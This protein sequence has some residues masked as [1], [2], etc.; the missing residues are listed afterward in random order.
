MVVDASSRLDSTTHL[1]S[2]L[3][4]AVLVVAQTDVVSLWSASKIRAF[5]EEGSGRDRVRLV[6]NRYKKIPGF[7]DED[8]AKATNCAL[9]WKLPN[10]YQSIAPAIDKGAPVALHDNHDIGRSF[11]SLAATLADASATAE[12]SLDLT[13]RHDK[14]DGKKKAAGRLLISPL[15][16]GQ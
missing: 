4:N 2:D 8:V 5:L 13:Y 7:S 16:A 10:N 14:A 15:R 6:L 11:R 3:S 1:L 9:L 12:G